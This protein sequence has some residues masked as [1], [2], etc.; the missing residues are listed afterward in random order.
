MAKTE[1]VL[2]MCC[3]K[4]G[5]SST[6]SMCLLCGDRAVPAGT[7]V[8]AWPGIGASEEISEYQ[9]GVQQS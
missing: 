3:K 2:E 8:D 5:I 4:L 1:E 7:V 6:G 9:L